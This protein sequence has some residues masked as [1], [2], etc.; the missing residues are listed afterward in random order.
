MCAHKITPMHS[1]T[2]KMQPLYYIAPYTE[3]LIAKKLNQCYGGNAK[4]IAQWRV[5]AAL[6]RLSR[7]LVFGV[8]RVNVSW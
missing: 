2:Y 6:H 1:C 7:V 8:R 4:P 5:V 3:F